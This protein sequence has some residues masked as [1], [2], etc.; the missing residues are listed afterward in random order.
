MLSNPTPFPS[1]APQD[2]A[3]GR[4]PSAKALKSRLYKA[5]EALSFRG[6]AAGEGGGRSGRRGE[7]EGAWNC[8]PETPQHHLRGGSSR[9]LGHAHQL[10]LWF[11]NTPFPNAS[12]GARRMSEDAADPKRRTSLDIT[13]K[14]EDGEEAFYD[15]MGGCERD[16]G[17]WVF[18]A[19]R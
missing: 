13:H 16:G 6:D 4:S 18:L 11:L 5:M 19:R 1:P 10:S 9:L 14:R 15:I 7:G 12:A 3:R 8:Q 2:S 17:R